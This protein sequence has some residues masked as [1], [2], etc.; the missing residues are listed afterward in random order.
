MVSE[1]FRHQLRQEVQQWQTEGLID[2]QLYAQLAQR[3]QFAAL[4]TSERNRFVM[5]LIGLGSILLGLAAITLV[6]AN[7]QVWSREVKVMLLMSLFVGVNIAGY[8]LWF[9]LFN[10]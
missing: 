6:A 1:K 5:I 10:K 8:S 7:W 4:D 3:Y 2:E 9:R